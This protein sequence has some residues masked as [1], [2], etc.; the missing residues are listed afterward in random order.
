[1]DV[2]RFKEMQEEIEQLTDELKKLHEIS[3][4][5]KQTN[6]QLEIQICELREK[7]NSKKIQMELETN[8][9]VAE[10]NKRISELQNQLQ[11]MESNY[12]SKLEES[13]AEKGK[14]I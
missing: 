1:M 14:F 9:E 10:L 11:N 5:E 8:F 12:N 7:L 13:K 2:N 3:E 6:A 4:L